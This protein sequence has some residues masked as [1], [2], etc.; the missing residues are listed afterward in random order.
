MDDT[1]IYVAITLELHKCLRTVHD[2][3]HA[4]KLKLNPDKTAFIIFGSSAHQ[5]S[6]SQFYPG[7]ILGNLLHPSSCV[8]NLGAFL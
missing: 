6:P 3:M 1:Q 4:S 2:W 7:I 8:C 5:A